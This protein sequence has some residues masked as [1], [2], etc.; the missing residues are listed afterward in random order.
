MSDLMKKFKEIY[1]KAQF[2]PGI[3]GLLSNPAYFSRKD[4]YNCIL[5]FSDH[6]NG[7]ILDVGCGKKPYRKLFK[8]T[9]Y[10]GL[11]LDSPNNRSFSYADFF[12]DG[13]T[14]PFNDE[15]FD[16]IISNQVL[17]HVD[18]PEIFLKEI[19]RVLKKGGR[20]LIS[21]PFIWSEHEQP[22][23]FLRF[24]S[25][26]IKKLL[27]EKGFFLLKHKKTVNDVRA[28]FLVL[29]MYIIEIFSSKNAY[30]NLIINFITIAPLNIVGEALAMLTPKTNALYFDN[31]ILAIK[32]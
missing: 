4:I 17:E 19:N 6:I 3:I 1:L 5:E 14:F 26:G 31:I 18:N 8:S 9:D 15:E 21:A 22:N 28:G 20:L 12:Y 2:E 32:K 13:Q 23:D 29:I 16:S 10:K 11:E 30:L 24:S 25:F 7:K 27:E